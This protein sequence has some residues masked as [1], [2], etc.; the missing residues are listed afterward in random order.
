MEGRYG[1]KTNERNPSLNLVF[2]NQ[3]LNEEYGE[4]IEELKREM[5]IVYSDRDERNRLAREKYDSMVESNP[6]GAAFLRKKFDDIDIGKEVDNQDIE[7][8]YSM[9][10]DIGEKMYSPEYFASAAKLLKGMGIE[11]DYSFKDKYMDAIEKTCQSYMANDWPNVFLVDLLYEPRDEAPDFRDRFEH[12]YNDIIETGF[13]REDFKIFT[14][15]YN[16]VEEVERIKN[17]ELDIEM[18]SLEIDRTIETSFKKEEAYDGLLKNLSAN[19]VCFGVQKNW[20]EL[21]TDIESPS[22]SE[23]VKNGKM[24]RALEPT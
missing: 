11:K 18:G 21:N 3:T 15:A 23:I 24:S 17:G 20:L 2:T 10:M 1:R 13:E 7:K 4:E 14:T 12:V 22:Y 5:D 6:M 19:P 8:A 9:Y 16:L